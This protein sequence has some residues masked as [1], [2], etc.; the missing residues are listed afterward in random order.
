MKPLRRLLWFTF[1]QGGE[2]HSGASKLRNRRTAAR[3]ALELIRVVA[4][5]M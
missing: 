3:R 5:G 4:E 1:R 2:T